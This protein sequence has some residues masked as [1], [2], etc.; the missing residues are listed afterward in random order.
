MTRQRPK[1]HPCRQSESAS[2]SS[3]GRN[4]ENLAL[5]HVQQ[6]GLT[7]IER[8]YRCRAGELDLIMRDGETLV[9][10]EVKYRGRSDFGNGVSQVDFRKQ[11]KLRRAALAF[12]GHNPS[13]AQLICRFDV[14]GVDSVGGSPVLSWVQNAF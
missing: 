13:L 2:A 11:Q 12:L 1:I 14:I 10:I 6:R 3:V 7:L 8:N 5:Q 4:Y 9:F